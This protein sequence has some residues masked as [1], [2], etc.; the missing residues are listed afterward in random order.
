[1]SGTA[2]RPLTRRSSL[3]EELRAL[4]TARD[5]DVMKRKLVQAKLRE[6]YEKRRLEREVRESVIRKRKSSQTIK[7]QKQLDDF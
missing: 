6:L 7:A 1:M 2:G 5:S 4:D 3:I